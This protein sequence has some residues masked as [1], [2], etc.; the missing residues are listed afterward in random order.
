MFDLDLRD[1]I[2]EALHKVDRLD[3]ADHKDMYSYWDLER[4]EDDPATV[5]DCVKFLIEKYPE[6]K[7][8]VRPKVNDPFRD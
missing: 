2:Y 3:L 6:K 7:I 8:Y 4:E 5:E 1:K